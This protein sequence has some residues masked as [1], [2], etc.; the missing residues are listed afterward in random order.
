MTELS[1][2]TQMHKL[3][4][5]A[6]M[7]SYHAC[8]AAAGFHPAGASSSITHSLCVVVLCVVFYACACTELSAVPQCTAQV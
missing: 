8:T 3:L 5:A 4:I 6:I 1:F 2:V 7:V